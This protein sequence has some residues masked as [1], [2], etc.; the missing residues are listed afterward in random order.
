MDI[1]RKVIFIRYS[2]LDRHFCNNFYINELIRQGFDVEYWDISNLYF[3]E[4]NCVDQID[5][6]IV[7]KFGSKR[8]VWD[9]IARENNKDTLFVIVI[10]FGWNVLWLFRAFRI[11]DCATALFARGY[12]PPPSS[13]SR[14][15]K[16]F[17]RL[18][19]QNPGRIWEGALNKLACVLPSLGLVK[20]YDIVFTAGKV[21]R[22]GHAGAQQL[23]DINHF[24]YD[25]YL[26]IRE[27]KTRLVEDRYAV[28]LDE[29]LPFHPDWHKLKMRTIAPD[30]YF[31]G[32]RNF[33]D[34]IEKEWRLRVVIAAHP[35]SCYNRNEFGDRL[36]FKY[37][38]NRLVKDCEFAFAHASTSIG[39]PVIYNKPLIFLY[40]NQLLHLG[41]ESILPWIRSFSEALGCDRYNVDDLRTGSQLVWPEVDEDRF[42]Q[43]QYDYLTS[44]NSAN[45]KTRCIFLDFLRGS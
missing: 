34:A 35:S 44:S 36:I 42:R 13:G 29:N 7:K 19:S 38:T 8:E 4:M 25:D 15:V 39:M 45:K 31:R 11:Y 3:P 6:S 16:F 24:D 22:A 2:P 33:F 18:V 21:A 28:F 1:F 41:D 23:I 26:S 9:Q 20:G 30:D 27:E 37:E 10:T 32:M 5:L 14:F 40:N 17:S 43:Y 12:L